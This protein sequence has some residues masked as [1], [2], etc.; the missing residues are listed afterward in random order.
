MLL[1]RSVEFK[2]SYRCHVGVHDHRADH[3]YC[4]TAV[5]LDKAEARAASF[6]HR[7]P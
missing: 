6:L 7:K 3:L 1:L 2:N 4:C 5:A